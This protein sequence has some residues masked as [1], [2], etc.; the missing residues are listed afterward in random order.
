ML[1]IRCR[2]TLGQFSQPSKQR[3]CSFRK[4]DR[5]DSDLSK[6]LEL[7]ASLNRIFYP[8]ELSKDNPL[9]EKKGGGLK[10]EY[11]AKNAKVQSLPNKCRIKTSYHGDGVTTTFQMPYF[12]ITT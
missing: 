5:K 2:N 8:D 4:I 6:S 3:N 9:V 12:N 10:I 1:D 11:P 7:A